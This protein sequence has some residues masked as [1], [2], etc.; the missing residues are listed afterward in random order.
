M[1]IPQSVQRYCPFCRKH[2]E[3]KITQAKR[4]TPGSAHPLARW[5]KKRAHFGK[6][7]GNLG[8]HGSKPPIKKWK[9]SGAKQSKMV[10]L[11]Y[12]C[13]VC[14][15]KHIKVKGRAKKVEITQ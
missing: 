13:K 14:K 1:K 6:G 5:A 4:R 8:N 7:A 15:K 11:R 3:H 10:D 9:Q 2:N 12:E